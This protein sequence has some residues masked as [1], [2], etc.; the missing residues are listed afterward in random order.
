[1]PK[2][3][4]PWMDSAT[5]GD[6]ARHR[7]AASQSSRGHELDLA[8]TRESAATAACAPA[9]MI[10][11]EMVSGPDALTIEKLITDCRL[12]IVDLRSSSAV[13][14]LRAADTAGSRSWQ[15]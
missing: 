2:L 14:T 1:M 7:L 12:M 8:W 13:P 15:S 6:D 9:S 11:Q 10:V 5:L 3:A 4:L